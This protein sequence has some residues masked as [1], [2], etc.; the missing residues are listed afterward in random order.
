VQ[1]AAQMGL[2]AANVIMAKVYSGVARDVLRDHKVTEDPDTSFNFWLSAAKGGDL[3]AMFVVAQ[4]YESVP[5]FVA[6]KAH[7]SYK[8]A[9]AWLHK[10]VQ[11]HEMLEDDDHHGGDEEEEFEMHNILARLAGMYGEGGHGLQQSNPKAAELFTEAA[12]AAEVHMKAKLAAKYYERAE[13]FEGDEEE[14]STTSS[15]PDIPTGM[16]SFSSSFVSTPHL[17]PQHSSNT[18]ALNPAMV[19]ETGK[20]ALSRW[21]NRVSDLDSFDHVVGGFLQEA[22][23]ISLDSPGSSSLSWRTAES[24]AALHAKLRSLVDSWQSLAATQSALNFEDSVVGDIKPWVLSCPILP[25]K[26]ETRLSL[27]AQHQSFIRTYGG[28]IMSVTMLLSDSG[29]PYAI[30]YKTKMSRDGVDAFLKADPLH[31]AGVYAEVSITEAQVTWRN[32]AI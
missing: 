27:E 29:E 30:Q 24:D 16:S 8:N 11:N 23:Q 12:G 22:I 20:M 25:H 3:N 9:A 19:G 21:V 28:N 18:L 32:P 15:A 7:K 1:V 14:D 13:E 4:Y 10:L 31:A 6:P 17:T 5:G 2:P 26:E